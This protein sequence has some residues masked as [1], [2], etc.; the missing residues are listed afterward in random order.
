MVLT[1]STY[2]SMELNI[3]WQWWGMHGGLGLHMCIT[4]SQAQ[5]TS[6]LWIQHA[7]SSSGVKQL[8]PLL[9]P[10]LPMAGP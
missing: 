7:E 2:L 6:C 5:I 4:R 1:C 9:L 3:P 10:V 8:P